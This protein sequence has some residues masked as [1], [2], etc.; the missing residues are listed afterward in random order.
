MSSS[1]RTLSLNDSG[2]VSSLMNVDGSKTGILEFTL[3]GIYAAI[4]VAQQSDTEQAVLARMAFT[5]FLDYVVQSSHPTES[6]DL[7]QSVFFQNAAALMDGDVTEA[8]SPTV[9][10]EVTERQGSMSLSMIAA[11]LGPRPW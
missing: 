4:N 2:V 10:R 3:S 6:I 9:H 5:N 11:Y 7:Q 1:S 8:A